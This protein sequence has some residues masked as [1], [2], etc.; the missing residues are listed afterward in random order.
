LGRLFRCKEGDSAGITPIPTKRQQRQCKRQNSW[1][2]DRSK[3][4][5][6]LQYASPYFSGKLAGVQIVCYRYDRKDNRRQQSERD[7][8][9]DYRVKQR[10]LAR[11]AA[12]NKPQ[13][14]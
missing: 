9:R 4:P 10:S 1:R 14:P 2:R 3:L 6:A 11:T 7:H 13:S 8:L 12:A 5:I